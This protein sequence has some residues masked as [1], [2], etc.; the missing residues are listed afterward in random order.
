MKKI[1]L[2][3]LSL[4]LM[5][6]FQAS[7]NSQF[8]DVSDEYWALEEIQFLTERGIINGYE[9]GTFKPEATLKRIHIA[10]MLD[11]YFYYS[12]DNDQ[13]RN[14]SDVNEN[15]EN[16]DV[17]Q[18][19]VSQGLFD[20]I[21]KDNKFEPYKNVTRAEMASILAK[22]FQLKA[23]SD[24]TISDVPD[25]HWAKPSIQAL[26]DHHITVL[27]EGNAF[28]PNEV[29]KRSQFSA[30]MA[31]GMNEYFLPI[32]K[33]V[34]GT[35]IFYWSS[36]SGIHKTALDT[37]EMVTLHPRSAFGEIYVE[38]DWIYFMD[39]EFRTDQIGNAV[40]GY[41]YRMK[42]DGSEKKRLTEDLATSLTL[43]NGK[44]IYSY[45][46]QLNEEGYI[47]QDR[48]GIK[49]MNLDGS[50]NQFINDLRSYMVTSNGEWVIFLGGIDQEG[51]YR[52]KSDGSEFKKLSDD[53]IDYYEGY[54]HVTDSKIMYSTYNE[55]VYSLNYEMNLDGTEKT[56]L[57]TDFK[58]VNDIY[59][60]QIIYTDVDYNS[61]TMSLWK[62]NSDFSNPVLLAENISGFYI[63]TASGKAWFYDYNQEG[64]TG[65][66]LE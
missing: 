10:L 34:S 26:I 31:R 58:Y 19:V 62:A 32:P 37:D 22:A 66:S 47:D 61:E 44:L 52:M 15:D 39:D 3:T 55:E 28:K 57:S 7:A 65:Y 50:E 36:W 1:L 21:I 35:D 16:Y 23:T 17:I 59:K 33:E 42:K 5:F 41:I 30:F 38:G 46:G 24:A 29:L 27:Y 14:L 51:I 9:D 53:P 56:L 4:F 18:A 48:I 63:G 2:L 45:Y 40:K 6:S 64:L 43:V 13:Y 11:R 54:L 60:D 49:S 20:Q 12:Y 8:T 25:N